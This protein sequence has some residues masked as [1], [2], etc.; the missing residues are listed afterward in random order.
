MAH[1][2]PIHSWKSIGPAEVSAL[3]LGAV[4]PSRSLSEES[5]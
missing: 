5:Q 4:L 1:L 3:K 2:S